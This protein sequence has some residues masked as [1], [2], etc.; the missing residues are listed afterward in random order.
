V[1]GAYWLAAQ[2]KHAERV[3]EARS[4]DLVAVPNK[5]MHGLHDDQ[6]TPGLLCPAH[7]TPQY[8]PRACPP[9]LVGVHMDWLQAEGAGPA[10]HDVSPHLKADRIVLWRV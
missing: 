3:E 10:N 4:F 8:T 7:S 9:S 2:G 5:L 6:P 1:E